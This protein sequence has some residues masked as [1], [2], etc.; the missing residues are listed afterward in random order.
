MQSRHLLKTLKTKFGVDPKSV[1][2]G[3]KITSKAISHF[4][5]EEL[6]RIKREIKAEITSMGEK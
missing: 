1:E 4:L 5:I 6:V 3:T 2:T